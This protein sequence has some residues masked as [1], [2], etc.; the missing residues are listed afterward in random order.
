MPSSGVL[1]T[2]YP[3]R[4]GSRFAPRKQQKARQ[5]RAF[6]RHADAA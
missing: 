2:T 3:E 5:L 1:G 6:F 4:M